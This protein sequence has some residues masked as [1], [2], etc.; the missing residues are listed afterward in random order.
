MTANTHLLDFPRDYRV[1]KEILPESVLTLAPERMSVM[2]DDTL[3]GLQTIPDRRSSASSSSANTHKKTIR[4]MKGFLIEIR[5]T[6]AKV[7]FVEGESIY[8]YYLPAENLRKA[9]IKSENQPFEM[10]EI[11]IKSEGEYMTGYRYRPLSM[12]N[13]AFQ[14]SFTLDSERVRKRD[15]IF[16][17]FKNAET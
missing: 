3:L 5:G 2:S 1:G 17:A 10:D 15:L 9:G 13:D 7:G 4:R 12:P 16:Q 14:D 8:E 6:E 11:E